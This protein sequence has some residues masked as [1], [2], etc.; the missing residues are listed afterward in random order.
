MLNKTLKMTLAG[1]AL[2]LGMTFAG[3]ASA[4][5]I[6][7]TGTGPSSYDI[8]TKVTPNQGCTILAPLNGAANDTASLV[9]QEGFFSITD[10]LF[11]GKYDNIN[12]T[13]GTDGS[14]LFN[15]T[16]GAQSGT[17]SK[18]G[19]WNFTDVMFVFKDG[20]DTNL[21]G[22]RI[23]MPV[24]GS[25]SGNYASP[26]TEPPFD[27]NGNNTRDISHISVYYRDGGG[28][29]PNI[30]V[31]EPAILGLLGLGLVVLSTIR[32]RKTA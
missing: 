15:F 7:C 8:S 31:P 18:V 17:F 21:V 27:F 9:N 32:L 12:A 19:T 1:S 14:T 16:G 26:F 30:V 11:D 29:P 20:G 2:A 22:Y 28:G 23:N 3:A 24:L 10:W 13:T 6:P 25:S 5:F 4:A